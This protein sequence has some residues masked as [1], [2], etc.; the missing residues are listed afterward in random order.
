MTKYRYDALTDSKVV[1]GAEE[2]AAFDADLKAANDD[3]AIRMAE[4]EAADAQKAT[5]K[6]SA[7]AKLITYNRFIIT[8]NL[9]GLIV[10]CYIRHF[11]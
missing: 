9:N 11:L 7:K 8:E 3:K 10:S 1:M 2:E 5:D 6:A 4:A